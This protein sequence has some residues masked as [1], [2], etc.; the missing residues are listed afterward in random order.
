MFV[1][2]VLSVFSG[3]LFHVFWKYPWSGLSSIGVLV[4]S[5]FAL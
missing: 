5:A 2:S 4:G 3:C 1:V